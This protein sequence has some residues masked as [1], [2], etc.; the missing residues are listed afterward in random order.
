MARCPH[1]SLD[2]KCGYYWI[3][4]HILH[5]AKIFFEDFVKQADKDRL[6][7][8]YQN[9]YISLMKIYAVPRFLAEASYNWSTARL[10]SDFF[11]TMD[12]WHS[13]NCR[14]CFYL[15]S[16]FTWATFHKRLATELMFAIISKSVRVT[17]Q[18]TSLYGTLTSE[19]I[20]AEHYTW[21]KSQET[22]TQLLCALAFTNVRFA[23]HLHTEEKARVKKLGTS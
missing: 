5:F 17:N 7:C 14:R 8:F 1:L 10:S 19:K 15:F 21:T 22:D 12:G 13:S 16:F 2:R 4:N 9:E 11:H 23:K 6:E 18:A 3:C 20:V